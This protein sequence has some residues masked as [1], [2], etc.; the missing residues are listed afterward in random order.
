M[1]RTGAALVVLLAALIH[2]LACAH[3]PTASAAGRAD[4]LLLTSAAT[5]GQAPEQP[6]PQPQTKAGQTVPAHH[7]GVH[8]WGLDE[9]TAQPPRDLALDV[10]TV[11]VA[12]LAEH[13]GTQLPPASPALHPSPSTPGVPS[14]GQTRS[15]LGVWRT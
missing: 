13:L 2:A 5:S 12:P 8:C 6:Q 4:S 15:R 11:H 7:N 9:P 10:P 3:G 14:A 1:A